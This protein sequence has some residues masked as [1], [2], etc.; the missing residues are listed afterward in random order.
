[1][2]SEDAF[3]RLIDWLIDLFIYIFF[4]GRY[5]G[6]A[7]HSEGQLSWWWGYVTRNAVVSWVTGVVICFPTC[8]A[9]W[10]RRR[11]VTINVRQEKMLDV[12]SVMG[13]LR[14]PNSF[15]ALTISSIHLFY[16]YE[17]TPTLRS[18]DL[19]HFCFYFLLFLGFF[20]K[21]SMMTANC[22][23]FWTLSVQIPFLRWECHSSNFCSRRSRADARTRSNC[24]LVYLTQTRGHG[25]TR[26][27]ST[28]PTC[29][30]S[31]KFSHRF[32]FE[33]GHFLVT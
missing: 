28:Q 7:K 30:S 27:Y 26:T 3:C 9:S 32:C 31:N 4:C 16:H 24:Q 5:R 15:P 25:M 14:L 2:A 11:C 22:T 20:S 18:Q 1:M 33:R 21:C 10:S 8:I 19:I 23:A 12:V 6:Y 17:W 29:V 13:M